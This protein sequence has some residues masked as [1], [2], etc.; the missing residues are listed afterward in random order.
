MKYEIV[1]ENFPAVVCHLDPNESM[2][3]E[4][5]SMIWMSPNMEMTTEAGGLGKMFGRALSGESIFMNHYKAVGGNGLIAFGGSFPGTII[6]LDASSGIVCQKRA[7]LAGEESVSLSIYFNQKLG[8][9]LFG[10][11]GFI[12]QKL[13]GTGTAFLE[14]DGAVQSY[15][16]GAGQKIIVDTGNLAAMDSTCKMDIVR[17]KGAKNLLFGGEGLFNT[18][19]TG[20]GKVWLQTMP[21]SGLAAAIMPYLPISTS[22]T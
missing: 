19:I 15:D 6:P 9:G 1:G 10:G 17:V 21:A 7:F 4:S 16:L 3:T 22:S 13:G 11:E 2:M 5:G 20:P 14:I 12:M 18:V 8:K